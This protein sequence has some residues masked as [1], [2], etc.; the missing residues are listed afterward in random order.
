MQQFICAE[1]TPQKIWADREAAWTSK[2]MKGFFER[3]GVELYH[4]DGKHGAAI[5][6]RFNR[7]MKEQMHKSHGDGKKMI[8]WTPFVSR[9]ITLY[10]KTE[11]KGIDNMKPHE[12]HNYKEKQ[13]DVRIQNFSMIQTKKKTKANFSIG[14]EVH[15]RRQKSFFEKGYTKTFTDEVFTIDQI[16]S[17]NPVTYGIRDK[18]NKIISGVFYD[19]DFQL[20]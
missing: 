4:T 1:L 18:S 11:H 10:N 8:G 19:R 5:V 6:E 14:D 9:F 20:A 2:E 16:K 15:I 3:E 17:S 12:V 13:D 7:T